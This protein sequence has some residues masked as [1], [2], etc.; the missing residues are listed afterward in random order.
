MA[1]TAFQ[2]PTVCFLA[3]IHTC[4]TH[5]LQGMTPGSVGSKAGGGA[6]GGKQAA[7]APVAKPPKTALENGKQWTVVSSLLSLIS[8]Q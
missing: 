4:Y 8:A 2:I 1:L 7:A 3:F 5:T 6:A